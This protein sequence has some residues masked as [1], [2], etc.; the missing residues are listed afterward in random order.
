MGNS[1]FCLPRVDWT[2]IKAVSNRYA[3]KILSKSISQ[4]NSYAA[5]LVWKSEASSWFLFPPPPSGQMFILIKYLGFVPTNHLRKWGMFQ[6]GFGVFCHLFHI[7]DIV[8]PA[9][10]A[11]FSCSQTWAKC[12]RNGAGTTVWASFPFQPPSTPLR[13]QLQLYPRCILSNRNNCL[14]CRAQQLYGF[15]FRSASECWRSVVVPIHFTLI[16]SKYWEFF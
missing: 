14:S 15:C 2:L 4:W 7:G 6:A 5:L 1:I 3:R 11:Q 13:G 12:P 10:A 9:E 8:S 16:G